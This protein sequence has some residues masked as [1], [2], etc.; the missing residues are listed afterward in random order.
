MQVLV[1]T[2]VIAISFFAVILMASLLIQFHSEM[3]YHR[4]VLN[5]LIE[6]LSP[7]MQCGSVGCIRGRIKQKKEIP[8]D[9]D[10]TVVD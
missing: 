3:R 8:N 2:I 7:H 4:A 5:R 6:K 9:R 10:T 1:T